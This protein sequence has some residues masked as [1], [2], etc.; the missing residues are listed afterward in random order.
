MYC[1]YILEKVTCK[2]IY[3]AATQS[4]TKK[5]ARGFACMFRQ[6]EHDTSMKY[7]TDKLSYATMVKVLYAAFV[8]T[9]VQKQCI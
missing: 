2:A 9:N 8:E 4:S 7:T 5:Y 3:L 6:M 1:M